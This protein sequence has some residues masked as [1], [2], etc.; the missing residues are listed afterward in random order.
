MSGV[1]EHGE[2]LLLAVG[3]TVGLTAAVVGVI[4]SMFLPRGVAVALP[5]FGRKL[6]HPFDTAR[7]AADVR[8]PDVT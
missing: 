6:V 7:G 8:H 1:L 5:E 4:F 3:Q 2:V